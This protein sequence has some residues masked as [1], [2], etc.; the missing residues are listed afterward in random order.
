M[1]CG[2]W[3]VLFAEKLQTGTKQVCSSLQPISARAEQAVPG[4]IKTYVNTAD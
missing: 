1:L 3:F 4:V 2:W